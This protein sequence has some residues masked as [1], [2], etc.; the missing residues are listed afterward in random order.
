MPPLRGL[1]SHRRIQFLAL[2]LAGS[3]FLASYLPFGWDGTVTSIVMDQPD[4][5]DAGAALMKVANPEAWD[6]LAADRRLITG[7]KAS[8]KAVSQCQTQ[9]AATHKPQLCQITGQPGA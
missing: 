7:N 8:A 1:V 4:R 5:W 2:G 9:V 6:T 3:P